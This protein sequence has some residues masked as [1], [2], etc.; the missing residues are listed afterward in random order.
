[1]LK[2][3]G[4]EIKPGDVLTLDPDELPDVAVTVKTT[5]PTGRRNP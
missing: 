2:N 1:M 3:S 4:T 5:P